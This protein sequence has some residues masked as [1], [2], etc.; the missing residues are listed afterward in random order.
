MFRTKTV[1][2]KPSKTFKIK[3]IGLRRCGEDFNTLKYPATDRFR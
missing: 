3:W 1:K 2:M